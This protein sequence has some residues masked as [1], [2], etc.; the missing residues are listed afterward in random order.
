MIPIVTKKP[1]S[2]KSLEPAGIEINVIAKG[3]IYAKIKFDNTGL[4]YRYALTE[5]KNNTCG[6]W[7]GKNTLCII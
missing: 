1:N 2:S 3:N 6:M 5:I 7:L 4:K